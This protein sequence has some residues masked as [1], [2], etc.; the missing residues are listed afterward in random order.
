VHSRGWLHPADEEEELD[1]TELL[2]N[3]HVAWMDREDALDPGALGRRNREAA[4][5]K[6][7]AAEAPAQHQA[8]DQQQHQQQQAA[9]Q[10]QQ[11]RAILQQ[12]QHQQQA[13]AANGG[14]QSGSAGQGMQHGMQVWST[15]PLFSA[16]WKCVSHNEGWILS[17]R[18][19]RRP[20][21]HWAAQPSAP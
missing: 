8:A 14:Q 11:Q 15:S 5:A 9:M 3:G 7:A 17:I 1:L 13:A 20:Y 2:E 18:E 19:L 12:Q 10:Q 4:A 6:Q 21:L 16:S